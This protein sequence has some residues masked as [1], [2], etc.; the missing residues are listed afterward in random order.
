MAERIE[1]K[2]SPSETA[3]WFIVGEYAIG[4]WIGSKRVPRRWSRWPGTIENLRVDCH[5]LTPQEVYESLSACG[6]TKDGKIF[7]NV[8]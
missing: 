6:T 3:L 7:I 4:T 5:P 8:M 2:L 1:A